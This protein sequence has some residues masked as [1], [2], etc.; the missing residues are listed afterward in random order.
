LESA[1]ARAELRVLGAERIELL[2]KPVELAPSRASEIAQDLADPPADAAVEVAVELPHEGRA[3]LRV[4][5]LAERAHHVDA[6][7]RLVRGERVLERLAR[8]AIAHE[9]RQGHDGRAARSR[10]NAVARARDDVRRRPV[11]AQVR[12]PLDRARADDVV[13][14]GALEDVDER[15]ER[16]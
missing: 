15:V 12:E 2:A 13:P 7:V 4:A 3:R 16:V 14:G 9:P 1:H 5:E 8:L 10:G 11:V 6:E